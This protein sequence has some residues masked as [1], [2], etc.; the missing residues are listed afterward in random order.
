MRMLQRR[1]K[2]NLPSKPFRADSCRGLRCQYLQHHSATKRCLLGNEDVAHAAATKLTLDAVSLA[3]GCLH[4][5]SKVHRQLY[6]LSAPTYG[7]RN[8]AASHTEAPGRR[9]TLLERPDG[10][11]TSALPNG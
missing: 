8:R 11:V 5:I 2:M 1:R 9:S 3:D 7:F 10:A 6:T 4:R